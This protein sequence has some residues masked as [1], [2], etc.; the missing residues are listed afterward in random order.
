[1]IFNHKETKDIHTVFKKLND[2]C[3]KSAQK[4]F[5]NQRFLYSVSSRNDC[6]VAGLVMKDFIF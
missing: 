1:M 5:K 3:L 2:T 6:P 4:F